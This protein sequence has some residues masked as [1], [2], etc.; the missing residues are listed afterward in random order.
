MCQDCPVPK[1]GT[2]R[3]C[4]AFFFNFGR[5]GARHETRYHDATSAIMASAW[6]RLEA[7]KMGTNHWRVW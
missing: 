2:V 6:A 1:G 3:F 4:I 5:E 7:R